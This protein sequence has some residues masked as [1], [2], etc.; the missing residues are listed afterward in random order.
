MASTALHAVG[1]DEVASS[2]NCCPT[3]GTVLSRG[4]VKMRV[5]DQ[6]VVLSRAKAKILKALMDNPGRAVARADI[7]KAAEVTQESLTPLLFSLRNQLVPFGLAIA[8]IRGAGCV[9][10]E[11][12]QS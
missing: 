10:V 1:G 7:A 4:T 5:K 12:G 8:T 2:T 6:D 9:L 11:V 3:C